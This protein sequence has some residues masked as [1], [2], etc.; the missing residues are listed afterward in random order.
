MELVTLMEIIT[1]ITDNVRESLEAPD[2]IA[3]AHLNCIHRRLKKWYTNLP[4]ALR[5]TEQNI[6]KAPL[7]FFLLQ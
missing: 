4:E 6:R 1:T 2:D 3:Y 7:S 5:W